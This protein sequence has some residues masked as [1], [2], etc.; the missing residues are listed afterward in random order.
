MI[1]LS[2]LSKGH[3]DFSR[4]FVDSL[5][6]DR[7]FGLFLF[8]TQLSSQALGG[9]LHHLL[10]EWPMGG[11]NFLYPQYQSFQLPQ[12]SFGLL[13]LCLF[14][15]AMRMH[16]HEYYLFQGPNQVPKSCVGFKVG[17]PQAPMLLGEQVPTAFSKT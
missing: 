6:H 10:H 14:P 5:L 17:A 11:E 3:L 1:Y 13:Y 12:V 15:D 16:Y 8:R 7:C 4:F 2:C 9:L